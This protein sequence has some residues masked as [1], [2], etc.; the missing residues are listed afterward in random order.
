MTFRPAFA[1]F[2]ARIPAGAVAR[3]KR[4]N[5]TTTTLGEP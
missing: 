5:G 3:T 2:A 4:V 1:M